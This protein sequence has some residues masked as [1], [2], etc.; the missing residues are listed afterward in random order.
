MKLMLWWK[1]IR[2][3][4]I[5]LALF[6]KLSFAM[7]FV[8]LACFFDIAAMLLLTGFVSIA[9]SGEFPNFTNNYISFK[10]VE[11]IFQTPYL[12][13]IVIFI[14]MLV[15]IANTSY[16]VFSAQ[17]ITS[18]LASFV[19]TKLISSS[20]SDFDKV[21]R[22]EIFSVLLQKL[23]MVSGQ[24]I[25]PIF[26]V[27]SSLLY[28]GILGCVAFLMAPKI[29]MFVF[30][31]F[32]FGYVL[33][34]SLVKSAVSRFGLDI[35]NSQDAL[36]STLGNIFDSHT[37]IALFGTGKEFIREYKEADWRLRKARAV[38][39]VVSTAP[40][41]MIEFILLL[42]VVAISTQVLNVNEDPAV[43]A[44]FMFASFKIFPHVQLLFVS[45]MQ[46]LGEKESVKTVVT[47][48]RQL[49]TV[50][51]RP[52]KDEVKASEKANIWEWEYLLADCISIPQPGGTRALVE[53]ISFRIMRGKFYVIT[54]ESGS[55]KSTL[56]ETIIGL[57]KADKHL[58]IDGV[59]SI[60]HRESWMRTVGIANQN[61]ALLNL[62][63]NENIVS[64]RNLDIQRL[65]KVI[66]VVG[67]KDVVEEFQEQTIGEVGGKLSGGQRQRVAIAR[68]LYGA[69]S[70][71]VLDE[72]MSGLPINQE[73]AILARIR[74]EFPATSIVYVSH[75]STSGCMFF[76]TETIFEI[77][78]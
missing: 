24:F 64:S 38:I 77:N 73:E 3:L 46:L 4:M 40:K 16:L 19:A 55:G 43:L 56:I 76:E 66:D 5:E 61:T 74:K 18:G 44:S 39:A 27:L 58:L 70:L 59:Q 9:V 62:T 23:H 71:L 41:F 28:I 51:V 22:S 26:N 45:V 36:S 67:L 53:D 78:L 11:Y 75:R 7:C 32:F 14:G 47:T 57:R 35:S 10:E 72:A 30:V 29:F 34:W 8:L 6:S 17:R 49:K 25:F 31:I 63:V 42:I 13:L 33:V 21:V 60:F 1:A 50:T 2:P 15:R 54:G 68:A 65:Y 69:P 48:F 52:I 20:L 37:Q 12:F